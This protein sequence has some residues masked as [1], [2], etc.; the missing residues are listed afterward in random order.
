VGCILTYNEER[1]IRRA[2]TSLR[3]AAD[4]VV[5]VDSGSTDATC[6]LARNLG[7]EVLVR[8]FDSYPRQRNW[9][10]HEIA[11]RHGDVWVFALDA[12]EWLNDDLVAELHVRRPTLGRDADVYIVKRRCRFDGRLLRH[13]GFG[14]TWLLR[15][16][17]AVGGFRYEDRA[18]NERITVPPSTRIGRFDAWLEHDDV[19]DWEHYVTK[20]NR[21]STL[22]AEARV[23]ASRA[24]P[25]V[26]FADVRRDPSRRGRW[27]RE[28]IWNRLPARPAVR[29]VQVYVLWAGWLDGRAGFRRAL[30]EAWQEMMTDLK[31]E[32]LTEPEGAS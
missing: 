14:R 24:G 31:A 7:A 1:N 32:R 27:L 6:D 2:V 8:P 23:F 29:F 9:A 10:L 19:A 5:V 11:E 28:R 25:G 18:V 15:L 30:F 22:E 16:V 13:G 12:D 20:H 21:Y 4:T 17:P 3:A 26:T